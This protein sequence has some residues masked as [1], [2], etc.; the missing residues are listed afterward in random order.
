MDGASRGAAR[1]AAASPREWRSA[2][3]RPAAR[4]PGGQVA[5][6]SELEFSRPGVPFEPPV[7][8]GAPFEL[9]LQERLVA[10]KR[11]ENLRLLAIELPLEARVPGEERRKRLLE[12]RDVAGILLDDELSDHRRRSLEVPLGRGQEVG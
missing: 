6:Q 4:S 9:G 12:E 11:R 1:R 8:R 7:A 5:L 10:S 3:P 2:P